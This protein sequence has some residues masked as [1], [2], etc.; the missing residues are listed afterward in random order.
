M[1]LR[2]LLALTLLP[3]AALAVGPATAPATRPVTTTVVAYPINDLI[4]GVPD[5]A[6]VKASNDPILKDGPTREELVDNL[7]QLIQ[8]V[9]DRPSW[10]EN[11]GA[12]GSIE[13]VD[14]T[15]LVTQTPE[16]QQMMLM[17]MEKLRDSRRETI[18]IEAAWAG[19]PADKLAAAAKA[20][21]LDRLVDGLGPAVPRA[22]VLCRDGQV[23]R[24]ASGP[25]NTLEI[26]LAPARP[27]AIGFRPVVTLRQTGRYLEVTPFAVRNVA[28]E[29][30]KSA[31]LEVLA[32]LGTGE[33][34]AMRFPR[35]ITIPL[36]LGGPQD[37]SWTTLREI[38]TDAARLTTSV[39]VPMDHWAVVGGLKPD[40]EKPIYLLARLSVPASK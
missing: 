37:F 10:R 24:L 5:E 3:T 38:M 20:G 26:D 2:L 36:D 12:V 15:L 31:S 18:L 23:A 17:L 32:I 30:A 21:T 7:I 1:T 29:K 39:T 11:G 33:S 25:P 22:M 34:Q 35:P 28:G 19:I 27:D 8:S 4:A 16:N 14:G 9:V 40:A 6:D 13:A